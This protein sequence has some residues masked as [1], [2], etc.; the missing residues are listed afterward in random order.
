MTQNPFGEGGFDLNAMLEQAQQMQA[1][2]VEAQQEL[3]ARTIEGTSGGVTVALTGTGDLTGVS[4]RPG[5]FDGDDEESLA[6]LGDLVVAAYRD[7]KAKSEAMTAEAL[8]PLA[9][10]LDALGGG[11]GGEPGGDPGDDEGRGGTGSIGFGGSP[12]GGGPSVV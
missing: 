2:L 4:I 6:D 12:G 7:A 9:G 1:Q 10:G 11:L 8:G 5:T 3:A